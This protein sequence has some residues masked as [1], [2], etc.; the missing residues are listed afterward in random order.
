VVEQTDDRLLADELEF[1]ASPTQAMVCP[2]CGFENIMGADECANCGSD[3]RTSDIPHAATEFERLLTQVPL[4]AVSARAP[5]TVDVGDPIPAV[6]AT[7]RDNRTADVLVLEDGR[8]V[9]IFTERDALVKLAGDRLGSLDGVRVGEV[10]TVDPVVLRA[11]DSVAVAVQ[12][13]AVGGFRHI[14][15]VE[16]GHPIGVISAIDVFRHLL[17]IVE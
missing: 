8:L 5:F 10:M 15:L 13:M 7:M 3:L 6:L 2:V 12:K 17:K 1:L 9:G 4:R 14:P 11:D 16:D